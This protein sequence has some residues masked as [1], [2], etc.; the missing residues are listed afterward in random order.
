MG[1]SM[2]PY[3]Q[4]LFLSS[5]YFFFFIIYCCKYYVRWFVN[6]ISIGLTRST[7]I[8]FIQ[9]YIEILSKGSLCHP[10]DVN[11]LRIYSCLDVNHIFLV[12]LLSREMLD[13][14]S[15]YNLWFCYYYFEI[16]RK[17]PKNAWLWWLCLE[18]I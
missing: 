18:F 6:Q 7:S 10:S 15:D 1:S 9:F 8:F 17:L 13:I 12:F 14:F 11:A 3:P 5:F 4:V 16:F 2:I